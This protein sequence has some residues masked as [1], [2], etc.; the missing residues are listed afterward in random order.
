[1]E[2]IYLDYAAT[3]PL[4]P[5]VREAIVAVWSD[6]G[7]PSSLHRWGRGARVRLVESRERL[8][9]VLGAR[10]REGVF[11]GS[12]TEAD[13]LAILGRWR[14]ARLGQGSAVGAPAV[15]V[16]VCS[17]IEHRAVLAAAQAAGREGAEVVLLGVDSAG[18][19]DP[20]SLEEAL[21]ARPALVSVMWAN[22]EVGTLQPV[23]ELAERCRQAGVTFHS[24]AVQA[25]GRE[26]IRLDEVPCDLLTVSAHKVGGPQGIGALYIREGVQLEPLIH[27][28]GQEEGRRAGTEA[29]AAAVGFAVAAELA[30][31][32]REAEAARLSNL[33]DHLE[34]GLLARIPGTTI[35]GAGAPRLPHLLSLN[36]PGVELELLLMSLDLEGIAASSG[37]ACRSGAVEPSHVLVAMGAAREGESP[38]RLSLGRETT[39][40]QID[41]ALERITRVVGKLQSLAQV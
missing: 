7:N 32:E 33:R 5:E 2:P 24:D 19:V 30:E 13:N 18:R 28:G 6:F 36:I 3:T 10:R 14:A 26:R 39:A 8:A 12:G 1:M 20:G 29:V 21:R 25:L 17:A 31:R 34:Q 15:G 9:A 16:I 38:L 22:N 4:R 37:S 27:G 35:N 11:T 41:L 23:R 40:A